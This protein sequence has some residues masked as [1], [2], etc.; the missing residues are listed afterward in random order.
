MTNSTCEVAGCTGSRILFSS[1]F[2]FY[3]PTFTS[4]GPDASILISLKAL[5]TASKLHKS[6]RL[7]SL[8][9]PLPTRMWIEQVNCENRQ[10]ACL[11]TGRRGVHR[12]G[13]TA[14]TKQ[15]SVQLETA[16]TKT[17]PGE[18]NGNLL[19]YSC[20]GSPMDRGAWWATVHGVER[21]GHDWVTKPPP[22]KTITIEILPI[23]KV[24]LTLFIDVAFLNLHCCGWVSSNC[25]EQASHWGDFSCC[26]AWPLGCTGSV[27]GAHTLSCPDACGIF[28]Y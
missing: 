9:S 3:N 7:V 19:Q 5:G 18:G 27:V 26:E 1:A 16:F 20:L 15:S 24:H 4:A 2:Y 23:S 12:E 22:T 14:T 17:I 11:G 21:V 6:L 25:E 28:P 8:M 13:A 10:Q